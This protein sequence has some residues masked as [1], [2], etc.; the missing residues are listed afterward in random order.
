MVEFAAVT[1]TVTVLAPSFSLVLPETTTE[2]A[3]SAAVATTETEL[4]PAITP[5]ASPLATI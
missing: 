5:M 3:L 2:A 1:T 4:V